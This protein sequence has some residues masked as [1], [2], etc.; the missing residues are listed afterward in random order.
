MGISIEGQLL[1]MLQAYFHFQ[2]NLLDN[3][4]NWNTSIER[5]LNKVSLYF[6]FANCFIWL[7]STFLLQTSNLAL[8]FLS[9]SEER[10]K[11]FDFTKFTFINELTFILHSPGVKRQDWLPVKPFHWTVWALVFASILLLVKAFRVLSRKYPNCGNFYTLLSIIF[12]Q[13]NYRNIF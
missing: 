11:S 8:C 3:H 5:V 7:W 1:G 13:C 2:V 10:S 12:K 9:I 4:R 6:P